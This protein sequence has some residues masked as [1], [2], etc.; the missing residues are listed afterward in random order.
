MAKLFRLPSTSVNQRLHE[1]NAAFLDGLQDVI[2]L[3]FAHVIPFH[4]TKCVGNRP[5]P[6]PVARNV[7]RGSA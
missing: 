5:L 2:A 6:H 7:E 3:L 4:D 1:A